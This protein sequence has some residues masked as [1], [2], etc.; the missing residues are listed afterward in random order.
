MGASQPCCCA[1]EHKEER[2]DGE[3]MPVVSDKPIIALPAVSVPTVSDRFGKAW[4]DPGEGEPEPQP[5]VFA[6]IQRLPLVSLQQS[7][8]NPPML[9][10]LIE[11]FKLSTR[12]GRPTS[13]LRQSG[14]GAEVEV[15]GAML[16]LDEDASQMRVSINDVV[17]AWDLAAVKGI[18]MWEGESKGLF[19][20]KVLN[21]VRPEERHTLLRLDCT[22]TTGRLQTLFIFEKSV[23]ERNMVYHGIR[24]VCVQ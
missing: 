21:A 4:E 14:G 13:L 18:Y 10:Q 23:E 9:S 19:L 2:H 16:F 3:A 22:S 11:T 6:Q 5:E 1:E 8:E 12:A 15:V 7:W 20:L 17:V 24:A